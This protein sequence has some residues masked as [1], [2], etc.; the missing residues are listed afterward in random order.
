MGSSTFG[1]APF[2]VELWFAKIERDLIYRGVFTSVKDLGPRIMTYIRRYSEQAKPFKWK[3]DDRHAGSPLLSIS[4]LQSTRNPRPS[5]Q[6]RGLASAQRV[7]LL[8]FPESGNEWLI[9]AVGASHP[10]AIATGTT[11]MMELKR[12]G[13]VNPIRKNEGAATKKRTRPVRPIVAVSPTR[14]LFISIRN[15]MSEI[16]APGIPPAVAYQRNVA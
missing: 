15:K 10:A 3:Y 16:N 8:R 12:Y 13:T 2:Q 11:R 14:R 5:G 1:T 9:E 6:R 4:V 7:L